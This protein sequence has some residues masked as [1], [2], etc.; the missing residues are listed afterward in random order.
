MNIRPKDLPELRA[1]LTAFLGSRD[2][3]SIRAAARSFGEELD[4][5]YFDRLE[6]LVVG[7]GKAEL[8]YVEPKMMELAVAAGSSLPAFTL[9]PEDVPS[10]HGF[11][12]F[13]APLHLDGA[14]VD[15]PTYAVSWRP[16]GMSGI[17]VDW[18]NEPSALA[19]RLADLGHPKAARAVSTGPRLQTFANAQAPYGK[20]GEYSE[21]HM[22]RLIWEARKSW[23]NILKAV[24]LLMQQP[25]AY[26]STVEPDRA[27]R[28]R[29][30]RA[31]Q[32][33]APVRVI[34]LRRPKTASGHGDG[35]SNYHH[36]WIVRGH[37]RQHWH[38]KRQVHRPVWIAPHIKGPEGAPL[39]GGE[40][41]YALKR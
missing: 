39:I 41:V 33:P 32:D 2:P 17:N 25:L 22:G 8:F 10:P 36:Q 21:G 20:H 40:K 16:D 29:M 4:G 23:L 28:K 7:L 34:E 11:I 3:E 24:W 27:A 30:R 38:P 6:S 19:A 18:Y 5:D 1:E 15:E 9:Q 37:W 14:P 35:E 26:A 13:G 31:S 12:Y